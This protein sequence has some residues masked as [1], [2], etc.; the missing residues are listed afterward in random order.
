MHVKQWHIQFFDESSSPPDKP[1]FNPWVLGYGKFS[2]GQIV[3][4]DLKGLIGTNLCDRRPTLRLPEQSLCTRSDH[5][6]INYYYMYYGLFCWEKQHRI[7]MQCDINLTIC[8][9]LISPARFIFG[10][11]YTIWAPEIAITPT[12]LWVFFQYIWLNTCILLQ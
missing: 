5:V 8:F 1:F 12:K 6:I 3:P 2:V 7:S 4:L 9:I 11:F 10:L